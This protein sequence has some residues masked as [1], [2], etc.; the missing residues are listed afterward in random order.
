[1]WPF[2]GNSTTF[3]TGRSCR[4]TSG[5]SWSST[6]KVS[7]VENPLSCNY[8]IFSSVSAKHRETKQ[9]YT[10]YN[11]LEDT[12]R[13]L[14]KE[15]SILNSI[16]DN[17]YEAMQTP[18]AKDQFMVQFEQIVEGIRQ[19]KA[20]VKTKHDEEKMK[21]DALNGQLLTL[22][23]QQRKYAAAIKQFTFE[24]QRNEALHMKLKSL[25]S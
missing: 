2:N 12:K 6:T 15:M 3:P 8:F 22:V 18:Q 7:I 14:E 10:L 5:G 11:T 23:E 17:Y 4:S 21:R 9:F 20:K 16:F 13:Y 19:T 25:T 1:V 24:C